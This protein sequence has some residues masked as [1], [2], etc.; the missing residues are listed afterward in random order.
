MGYRNRAEA[1]TEACLNEA[2]LFATMCIL[3]LPVDVYVRD[4]SVYFGTFHTA[5]F[6]K[7][8]GIVLKDA[9]LTKKGKSSANVAGGSVI[10]TLVILSVDIVQVVAKGVLFPADGVTANISGDNVEAAV[11]NA[12][13]SEIVASEANKSNKF[14]ADRKESNQNR[15]SAKNKNGSSQGIMLTKAGKD[16]EERKM[17]PNDTGNAMEFEHGK[18]D[19]VNI[20]KRGAFSGDSVNGRQTGED[21]SQDLYKHEFEFQREKSADEVHSL[22]ATRHHLSEAKPVAEG[23]VTVNLLPNGVSCNSAGKLMKPDNRYCG[24]PS[25]VGTTSPIA[26]CASVSTSSNPT[27]D[28]PSESLCSSLANST[29]AISPQISGSNRGSK[30]FKLNPGAKIFSPSF[31]NP[32]SATAPAVPTAASMA[33]I[34]SNFPVVPFAAVQPE[35]GIPFAPRSSVPAKLPPYS[36]LTAVNGGSGSQFLQPIVGHMGSR[37]QPQPLRYSVQYHA[38]QAAPAFVPQNSQSVMDGQMGQLVYIQPVSHDLVP[39]AAAIS[40]V[41]ARPMLT[42]H[43]VQYPKHQGRAA[44][45]TL[46]LCVT[47]PFVADGQQ[48]FVAPSHVPFFQPPIPAIRPIPVPGSNTFFNTKFP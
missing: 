31:S 37:A 43:Q 33:Y 13:S 4:G 38:V 16:H 35:V 41:S 12:P 7:E 48:P 47:P 21:W 36:N 32:L 40:S 20:S 23:Q 10:E 11:T 25:S 14:T 42:P 17:P 8:N 9:R 1:E 39:S 44:G 29:D 30:A 18:R 3:G 46:H 28:V 5:S 26:V 27:V 24:G 45:Q 6:D 19:D 15:G 2:L 22:N 34:P